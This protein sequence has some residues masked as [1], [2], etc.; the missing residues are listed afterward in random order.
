V[1][2]YEKKEYG[3]GPWTEKVDGFGGVKML[4]Y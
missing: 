1:Q 2:N 4:S 3:L